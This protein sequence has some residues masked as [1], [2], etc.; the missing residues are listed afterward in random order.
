MGVSVNRNP[1]HRKFEGSFFAQVLALPLLPLALLALRARSVARRLAVLKARPRG[2]RAHPWP[3]PWPRGLRGAVGD[4]PPA[5]R[6]RLAPCRA[7]ARVSTS[8]ARASCAHAT[9]TSPR[10]KRRKVEKLNAILPVASVGHDRRGQPVGTRTLG[11]DARSASRS[12]C[13]RSRR[14]VVTIPG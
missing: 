3:R 4:A 12:T 8:C 1:S 9:A 7:A 14:S 11:R 13:T 10:K 2:R 6:R 5:A